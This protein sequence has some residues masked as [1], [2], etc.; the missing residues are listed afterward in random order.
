M[1]SLRLPDA[2]RAEASSTSG[3]LNVLYE[4]NV[5]P[6]S[7]W[8]AV[9]DGFTRSTGIKVNFQPEPA[10]YDTI[11]EKLTTALS[12]GYTGYDV[13]YVDDIMLATFAGAGWLLPLQSVLPKSDVGALTK[14]HVTLSSYNGQLYRMPINQSFYVQFYRK[15]LLSSAGVAIPRTWAE[16]LSAGRTM[17]KSGK[18]GIALAGVPS[19][20]FDDFL[21][22]MPQAGGSFLHL[23]HPGT[24]SALEFM[25]ELVSVYKVVPPSY[26]TDSYTNIPTYVEEGYVALWASW[27]GFMGE[28]VGDKTFWNGGKTLGV[29]RPAKGPVGDVTDIGDWGFSISKYSPRA[30]D[31]AKFIAYASSKASEVEFAYT[32]SF[33]VRQDAV[34]ASRNILVAGSDFAQILTQIKEVPRP[35]TPKTTLIQNSV[36]PILVDYVAGKTSLKTAVSSGQALIKQYS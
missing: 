11:V 32:Q 12:S 35:I 25:H 18:Y 22:F 36:T 10:A 9:L 14:A 26:P 8:L 16:L 24:Q 23:D 34:E 33:P 7:R 13:L 31:A 4:S 30:A 17:T 21:Y 27:N 19:D 28:F 5:I 20:A 6:E 29:T 3:A 2:S 1:R 15:D